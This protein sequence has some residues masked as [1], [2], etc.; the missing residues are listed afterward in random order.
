MADTDRLSGKA[1]SFTFNGVPIPITKFTP[2]VVRGMAD[3]TDSGDYSATQDMLC[4]TQIPV[5]YQVEAS[6]EGR[7]RKSITPSA[8]IA[9]AMTSATQI[10]ITLGLDA[11]PT[12]WGHGVCDI[13]NFQTDVPVDDIV[14]FTC[15]V[16]SWGA[17]TPNS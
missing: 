5:T 13:F 3:S 16:K 2:K 8:F 7:F 6:V 9:N 15:D 1:S 12:I 11:S 17:F 10:P 14:T 4:K